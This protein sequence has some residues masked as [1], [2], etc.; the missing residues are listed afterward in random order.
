MRKICLAAA[1]SAVMMFAALPGHAA[2]THDVTANG[3]SFGTVYT[4]PA[5][6]AKGGDSI[7][8]INAD[9]SDL[10]PHSLTFDDSSALC[11]GSA[12]GP[13]HVACTT[14][15]IGTAKHKTITLNDNIPSGPYRFHCT[16]HATMVGVVIVS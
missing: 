4:A 15:T 13:A 5:V 16:V 6:Q 8:F 2:A 3:A 7:D 10:A 14:G 9:V 1:L 12:P 11:K